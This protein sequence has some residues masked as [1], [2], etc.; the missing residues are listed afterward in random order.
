MQKIVSVTVEASLEWD[1]ITDYTENFQ[2]YLDSG[3]SIQSIS[4]AFA[5]EED[6]YNLIITVVLRK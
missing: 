2:S 3:W 4:T 1:T 5:E 6:Y